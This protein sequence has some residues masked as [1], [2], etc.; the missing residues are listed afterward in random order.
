MS[1]ASHFF[2]AEGATSFPVSV[3][4]RNHANAPDLASHEKSQKPQKVIHAFAYR[5]RKPSLQPS[6]VSSILK[7]YRTNLETRFEK[8]IER[9]AVADTK[10]K[11]VPKSDRVVVVVIQF[12]ASEK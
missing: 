6:Y 7:S 11:S 1:I 12:V 2:S 10:L 8:G 5:S 3:S 4:H 9:N